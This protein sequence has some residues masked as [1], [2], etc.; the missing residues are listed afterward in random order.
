L[1]LRGMRKDLSPQAQAHFAP[2]YEK[3]AEWKKLVNFAAPDDAYLIVADSQGLVIWQAHGS[4]SEAT[5]AEL[6]KVVSTQLEKAPA[7]QM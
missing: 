3:Q 1:I 6:K 5:Y 2:L 4:F 7:K